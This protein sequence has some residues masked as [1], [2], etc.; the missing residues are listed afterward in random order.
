MPQKKEVYRQIISTP[1]TM[2]DSYGLDVLADMTAELI[3]LGIIDVID[4]R[5]LEKYAYAC[6]Q[7]NRYAVLSDSTDGIAMTDNGTMSVHPYH[8]IMC[9]YQKMVSNY[10]KEFGLT[11]LARQKFAIKEKVEIDEMEALLL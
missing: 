10:E 11:P 5:A 7:M 3:S 8:K 6:Q 2:L 1:E 4:R 9:D